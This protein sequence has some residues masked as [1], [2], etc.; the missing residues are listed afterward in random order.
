MINAGIQPYGGRWGP[1]R[2]VKPETMQVTESQGILETGMK[3]RR[4]AKGCIKE[5]NEGAIY[6]RK[7][8][9][10]M[11]AATRSTVACTSH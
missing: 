3:N 5:E 4:S 11:L 7:P 8:R 9:V 10:R 1:F 6:T 2:K